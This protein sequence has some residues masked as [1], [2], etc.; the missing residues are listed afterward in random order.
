MVIDDFRVSIGCTS[1]CVAK[2]KNVFC[3]VA[4]LIEVKQAKLDPNGSFFIDRERQ[5]Y[6]KININ[7]KTE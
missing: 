6:E 1:G 2:F 3:Q 7:K 5:E 4:I